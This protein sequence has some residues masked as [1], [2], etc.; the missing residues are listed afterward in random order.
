MFELIVADRGPGIPEN[1]LDLIFEKFVQSS[2]TRSGA[3]GT[4]LGLAI[5]RQIV[6]LHRGQIFARARTG[7]GAEFVVRLP[8]AEPT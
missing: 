8:V 1:E 3:G 5:C 6:G 7:G 2:A 4:G